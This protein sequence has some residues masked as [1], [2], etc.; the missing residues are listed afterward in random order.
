M[1]DTINLLKL[2]LKSKRFVL[3]LIFL[4]FLVLVS[5]VCQILTNKCYGWFYDAL[6]SHD[7]KSGIYFISIYSVLMLLVAILDSELHYQKRIF[8]VESR[9]AIYNYYGTDVLDE[10][11]CQFSCQRMSQDVLQFGWQFVNLFV[12]FLHSVL[13]LPAFVYVLVGIINPWIVFFIII[14]TIIGSIISLKLSKP[15]IKLQYDQESLEGGLRRRLIEQIENK[16]SQKILPDIT[17]STNNFIKLSK[18]ERIMMYCKN[19][20]DRGGHFLPYLF[21]LPYYF[22]GLLGLGKV[23]QA[24][25]A[26]VKIITEISFFVNNIDKISEFKATSKRLV[27]LDIAKKMN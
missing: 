2:S 27:E 24:G 10:D 1:K 16:K 11:R 20:Y 15:V 23:V 3:C 12:I 8:S 19:I 17:L 4:I 25:T 14:Y 26:L 5:V 9:L 7:S 6:V 13:I 18:K 22:S 21:I